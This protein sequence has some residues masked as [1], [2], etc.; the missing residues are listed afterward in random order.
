[1]KRLFPLLT[2]AFLK[3]VEGANPHSAVPAFL[4]KDG[5]RLLAK[6]GRGWIDI[7]PAAGGKLVVIATG[8]AA[9]GMYR[10]ATSVTG[11]PHT[12][13]VVSGD[14]DDR[15]PGARHLRGTHPFPDENSVEAAEVVYATVCG[16]AE[17]DSLFYLLSGGSSSMVC[18][19]EGEISLEEKVETTRALM[20]AGASIEELNTVRKA[21]SRVKGGKLAGALGTGRGCVLVISDVPGNDLSV[22]G[23]GP[24]YSGKVGSD[25]LQVMKNLSVTEK[26]PPAVVR[27]LREGRNRKDAASSVKEIPHIIIADNDRALSCAASCLASHGYRIELLKEQFSNEALS[28]G[29]LLGRA[30]R[31]IRESKGGEKTALLA[32]GE[33]VV[34]VRGGGKG[35]RNQEMAIGAAL[36]LSGTGGVVG[37][38]AGTDGT[39]GNSGA[40]GGFFDGSLI[41]RARSI[42]ADYE[43]YLANSDS[44]AFMQK[45]GY[46][47]VTGP[48]GTNVMD[49]FLCLIHR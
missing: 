23:S 48:T 27:F 9:P 32:G 28:A 26:I 5:C 30:A 6:G 44:H 7:S 4:R 37:L 29:T 49:L 14:P 33:T 35:G 2:E 31:K 15:L 22:V 12:G 13:I 8:K 46:C 3:G 42:G 24:L 17:E 16:L 41:E 10:A 45:T 25:P 20:L 40:A 38:C 36:S 11:R 1:M 18:L 21:I 34:R 39:D 47:L 19:P 43:R